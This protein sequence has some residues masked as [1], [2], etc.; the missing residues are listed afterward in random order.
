MAN[1]SSNYLWEWE[2]NM[3]EPDEYLYKVIKMLLLLTNLFWI[4]I[5]KESE[6]KKAN[7]FTKHIVL[8]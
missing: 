1:Q 7:N 4:K 2:Y 6:I 3:R 8:Y 5:D